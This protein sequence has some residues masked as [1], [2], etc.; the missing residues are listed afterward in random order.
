MMKN[1]ILAGLLVVA[2]FTG[3]CV[4]SPPSKKMP[5]HL[6]QGEKDMRRGIQ[7]YRKGCYGKALEF[8][9]AAHENFS[10][11]DQVCGVARSL[12]SIAN[13]YRNAGDLK[14]ALLFFDEAIASGRACQTGKSL[15][16][17]LANKSA[18]LID[19]GELDA[20]G[21][22]LEKADGLAR[23]HG[24]DRALILNSRGILL[25]KRKSFAEAEKILNLALKRVAKDNLN[26][27]A[28]IQFTFGTLLMETQR[29][30]EALTYFNNAL[31][32]D[33]QAGFYRGIADDLA[34]MGLAHEKSGN[35]DKAVFYYKRS[36]KV[37]A[38]F[39]DRGKSLELLERIETLAPQSE[40]DIRITIHFVKKWLEDN[41]IEQI[42][43]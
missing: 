7:Y 39:N 6:G 28:T 5:E 29:E 2:V 16:Q 14:S 21:A 43:E 40:T 36:I 9:M 12:N 37:Y 27:Y 31:D 32:A 35:L 26:E 24:G 4:S 38:L 23:S 18:T 41:T 15:I 25:M 22:L 34:S 20:A 19:A 3:A 13:V 8:F 11:A 33:R 42:C 10:A 1:L 17:A 30:Q